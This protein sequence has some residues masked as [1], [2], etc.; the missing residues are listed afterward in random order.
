MFAW[1][2]TFE[3]AGTIVVVV[4]DDMPS[5]ESLQG[6]VAPYHEVENVHFD[7]LF[8][9]KNQGDTFYLIL[10]QQDI[11]WSGNDYRD[12]APAL[13]VHIYRQIL[14]KIFPNYLSLH[15]SCVNIGG[16]ACLFAAVS[17]SGKSSICTA[18]LLDGAAY[19][20]DEF[21]LLDAYGNVFPFPRPLQWDEKTHPAFA[22]DMMLASGYFGRASFEFLE[23]DTENILTSYLWL[24]QNVQHDAL[25]LQTVVIPQ[26]KATHPAAELIPIRRGEALMGL[27][28]HMHQHYPNA[29]DIKQLNQRLPAQCSFYKLNFSDVYTAWTSIKN[30]LS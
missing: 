8:H 24:P 16:A 5:T 29:Q 11:L 15:A 2:K 4:A 27:L 9:I 28:E 18:A 14:D 6:I 12:I 13:E 25:P 20:T 19:C 1:S 26:Y 17:G 21:T 23:A 30:E 10:N 3:V 22:E 7:V